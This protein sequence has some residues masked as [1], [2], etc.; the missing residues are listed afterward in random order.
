MFRPVVIDYGHGGVDGGQYKPSNS[1]QYTFTDRTPNL[2]VGEGIINRCIA[3]KVIGR[4]I[5]QGFVVYDA[6]AGK[7]WETAPTWME[8][9]QRDVPLETRVAYANE[10]YRGDRAVFVSLHSNAIGNSISGPSVNAR[11]ISIFTS[12]GQTESDSLADN[13][14]EA[15][16][17]NPLTGLTVRRGDWSDGDEDHEANFYVLRNTLG[18]AVLVE[19]GF[20]TN[21]DDVKALTSLEGQLQIS[22]CYL[23]GLMWFCG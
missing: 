17:Q 5:N 4:L 1:K 6:V 16:K 13:L 14:Y 7:R 21:I 15:F 12:V 2:W 3:A 20:F 22:K 23:H 19:C 10:K 18:P 9:E 8:L 11:G